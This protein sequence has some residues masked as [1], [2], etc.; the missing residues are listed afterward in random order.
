MTRHLTGVI[1]NI[2][3]FLYHQ[4]TKWTDHDQQLYKQYTNQPP[5]GSRG[6]LNSLLLYLYLKLVF[7]NTMA[8]LG[9]VRPMVSPALGSRTSSTANRKS[10][11]SSWRSDGNVV[12][13][14]LRGTSCHWWPLSP[15]TAFHP[16]PQPQLGP[17]SCVRSSKRSRCRPAVP[18]LPGRRLGQGQVL[19]LLLWAEAC[20]VDTE[21]MGSTPGEKEMGAWSVFC[22]TTADIIS[23]MPWCVLMMS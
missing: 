1:Q 16:G 7:F 22:F 20:F 2:S 14:V 15:A 11:G 12:Q 4:I 19:R 18:S 3:S 21:D 9:S 6:V 23:N 8:D 5:G 17:P 13:R 10:A